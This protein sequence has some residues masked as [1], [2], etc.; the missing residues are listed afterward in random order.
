[1]RTT[2]F[3]LREKKSEYTGVNSERILYFVAMNWSS[4]FLAA[5][6]SLAK[7]IGFSTPVKIGEK[8]L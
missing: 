8:L 5:Y 6:R 1:V 7:G 4:G 3:G 2:W